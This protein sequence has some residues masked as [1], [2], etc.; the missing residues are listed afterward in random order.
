MTPSPPYGAQV[1]LPPLPL[2]VP[3]AFRKQA[4][5][6]GQRAVAV[7]EKPKP[8]AVRLSGPAAIP[9]LTASVGRIE[10]DAPQGLAAAMRAPLN[11]A[12]IPVL[13]ADSG[14]TVW[15]SVAFH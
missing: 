7:D 8:L 1:R 14:T 13:L 12:P 2:G 3:D 10:P 15:A 4:I 9:P 5:D 6:I 11:V